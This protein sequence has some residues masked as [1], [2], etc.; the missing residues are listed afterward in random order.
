MF[1]L[2]A[3]PIDPAA[4]RAGMADRRAGGFVTF[5]GWVREMN[6]G[7]QVIRLEYEAFAAL[8]EKEGARILAEAIREYGVFDIRCVHRVGRLELGDLAVWIGVSA[9]HRTAA[10]AACR[11]VIDEVKSRVPIWKKEHYADGDSGW[12]GAPGA[13]G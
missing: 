11:R 12:I 10:F 4:L 7:R 1:T 2:S 3:T 6:E 9:Q 13:P 8:A 5:E